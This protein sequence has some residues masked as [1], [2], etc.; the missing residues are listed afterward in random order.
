[1]ERKKRERKEE[2]EDE[3]KTKMGRRT[4]HFFICFLL[5]CFFLRGAKLKKEKARGQIVRPGHDCPVVAQQDAPSFSCPC[6]WS[7]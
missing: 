1:M 7:M 6:T 3:G 4:C 2:E 5:V